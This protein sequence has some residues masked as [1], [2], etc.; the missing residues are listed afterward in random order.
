MMGTVFSL[1]RAKSLGDLPDFN[2]VG[3]L[4]GFN[5]TFMGLKMDEHGI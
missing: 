2:G 4:Y 3:I 1:R 5:G